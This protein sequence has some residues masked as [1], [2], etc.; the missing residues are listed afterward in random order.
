[1]LAATYGPNSTRSA[2][3]RDAWTEGEITQAWQTSVR[4]DLVVPFV[5]LMKDR[6]ALLIGM[7]AIAKAAVPNDR[8][9]RELINERLRRRNPPL[10]MEDSVYADAFDEVATDRDGFSRAVSVLRYGR[11]CG[12]SR[13]LADTFRKSFDHVDEIGYWLSLYAHAAE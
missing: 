5:A 3:V 4:V 8:I 12:T 2:I 7:A 9:L 11:L 1:V 13:A 6:R 10:T